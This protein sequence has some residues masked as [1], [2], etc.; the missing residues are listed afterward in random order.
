MGQMAVGIAFLIFGLTIG[1]VGLATAGIGIGIPMI[2]LGIYF[3]IRGLR[4]FLHTRNKKEN[5]DIA[6]IPKQKIFEATKPG[7]ICLGII[8]ILIGLATS[9]TL[10][11]IPIVI[12][13][14]VLIISLFLGK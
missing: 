6:D 12:I 4:S 11:G 14:V 8:L 3:L 2:P 13:G 9:A 5:K 1:G 10:I 7:R